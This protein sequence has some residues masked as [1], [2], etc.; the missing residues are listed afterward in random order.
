MALKIHPVGGSPLPLLAAWRFFSL[1]SL[2]RSASS[3]RA[4]TGFVRVCFTV[5]LFGLH[6]TFRN[7]CEGVGRFAVTSFDE[8]ERGG[9]RL[10]VALWNE[11]PSGCCSVHYCTLS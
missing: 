3:R 6:K 1:M 2:F 9:R 5:V 11:D 10:R 4:V 8:G 7:C